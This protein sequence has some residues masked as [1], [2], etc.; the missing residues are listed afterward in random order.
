MENDN[1]SDIQ[2]LEQLN[3]RI[4]EEESKGDQESKN[5]L[6]SILAPKLAFRRADGKTV[7]DRQEFLAKVKPSDPRETKV[8]SINVHGDRA[9]VSCIVTVNSLNGDK[10]FHN[11]RLFVRQDG[12]WKL[13][14]WANELH[15]GIK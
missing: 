6:D 15:R 1:P 4:G 14:G 5:W 13:L 12:Q 7:D 3:I 8:T 11:L 9:V 10:E 2:I